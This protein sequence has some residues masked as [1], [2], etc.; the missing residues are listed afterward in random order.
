MPKL[1]CIYKLRVSYDSLSTIINQGL[2]IPNCVSLCKSREPIFIFYQ[3][4][5]NIFCG[6]T[7]QENI[8]QYRYSLSLNNSIYVGIRPGIIF[9]NAHTNRHK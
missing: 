2:Y 8:L 6:K 4:R 5:N 3:R 9:A 7:V 1:G